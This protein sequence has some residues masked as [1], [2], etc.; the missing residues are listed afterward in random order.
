MKKK[1]KKTPENT[2]TEGDDLF[3]STLIAELTDIQDDIIAHD[4]KRDNEDDEDKYP[5]KPYS[6]ASVGV[7]SQ[8]TEKFYIETDGKS[9]VPNAEK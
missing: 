8:P 5:R 2:A 9:V 4:E 3:G 1:A 6:T 7:R